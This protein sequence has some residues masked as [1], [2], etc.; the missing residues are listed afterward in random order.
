MDTSWA[1]EGGR[2]RSPRRRIRDVRRGSLVRPSRSTARTVRHPPRPGPPSRA[3]GCTH[4]CSIRSRRKR[5]ILLIDE[6]CSQRE[7]RASPASLSERC[8]SAPQCEVRWRASH[9]EQGERASP[10]RAQPAPDGCLRWRRSFGRRRARIWGRP[11]RRRRAG[12]GITTPCKRP[13]GR[14][15]TPCRA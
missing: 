5:R 15:S 3:R 13:T 12:G 4:A 6:T 1:R 8:T 11:P 9:P 14:W 2:A 7:S 10:M